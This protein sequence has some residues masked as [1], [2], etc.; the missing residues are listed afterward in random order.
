[1]DIQTVFDFVDDQVGEIFLFEELVIFFGDMAGT[2]LKDFDNEG[3]GL[4]VHVTPPLSRLKGP[5]AS[6]RTR[7]HPHIP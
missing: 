3:I 7:W 4:A 2:G 6:V 1:M 5:R